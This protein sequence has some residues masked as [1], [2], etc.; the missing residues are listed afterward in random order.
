MA[1][2]NIRLWIVKPSYWKGGKQK[3][4]LDLIL[5]MQKSAQSLQVSSSVEIPVPL[6]SKSLETKGISSGNPQKQD[7]GAA[8]IAI[9]KV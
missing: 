5:I 1:K 6:Q 3:Y 2:S 4:S 7:S 9:P 8:R